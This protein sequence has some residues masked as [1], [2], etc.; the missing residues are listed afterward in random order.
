MDCTDQTKWSTAS[1][2]GILGEILMSIRAKLNPL[3]ELKA[4][5]NNGMLTTPN[6]MEVGIEDGEL[7]LT[8][9]P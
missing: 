1:R 5:H 4:V 7:P 3:T 6:Q 8:Q 9:K 2:P